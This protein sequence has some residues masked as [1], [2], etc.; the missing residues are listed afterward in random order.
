MIILDAGHGGTDPGAIANGITE[1]D[2]NLDITLY[3]YNR[4]NELG[5]PANLTRDSDETLIPSDRINR[6]RQLGDIEGNILISNHLNAADNTNA[7]GA[8][9]IYALRSDNTLPNLILEELNNEGQNIRGAYQRRLPTNSSRDYYFLMRETNNL[10]PIIIEYGF[11]TSNHDD[12]YQIRT[13]WE[14]FAEAVVRAVATYLD[15]PYQLDD[16]TNNTYTVLPGDSIYAIAR[17]LN[18]NSN[19]LMK[20]NNLNT[21]SI[22]NIGQTLVLPNGTTLPSD[23]EIINNTYIVQPGDSIYAIARKLYINPNDFMKANNLNTSSILNIGQTLVLPI[24]TTLPPEIELTNN[25]YTVLPGDSIYAIARKLNIN[26]NDLMKANNLNHSS[27]L[28]IGDT[29]VLPTDRE[30]KIEQSEIESYIVKPGD[31]LYGIGRRYNITPEEIT[32]MNNLN[33]NFIHVGQKLKIINNNNYLSYK[34]IQG[35]TLYNLAQQHNT[36]VDKIKDVNNLFNDVLAVGQHIKIPDE[37]QINNLDENNIYTIQ[38]G[39]TLY[40]IASKFDVT[41]DALKNINSLSTPKIHPNQ[42][43]IISSQHDVITHTVSHGDTLYLIA[44]QYNVTVEY[45]RKLNNLTSDAIT[46]GQKII[47]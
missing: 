14:N 41:V 5:I 34:V 35:D 18:I 17:K 46:I 1:K 2:Y 37:R 21:S 33:S 25:T 7:D 44:Q 9:V 26:P 28:N 42:K 38:E 39:D 45:L 13:N 3:I 27:I 47:I 15:V 40:G 20:A 29:L 24:G 36:T 30:I 4:L 43:L 31:T 22:L 6:I 8:E 10:E 16:A 32:K 19:E 11:V 23:E 12:P